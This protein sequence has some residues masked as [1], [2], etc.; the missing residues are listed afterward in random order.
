M[1]TSPA[2][3]SFITVSFNSVKTIERTIAS[4]FNQSFSDHEYL[5]IDGGSTDGIVEVIKRYQEHIDYFIS[6]I[7]DGIYDAMNKGASIAMGD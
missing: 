7:D 1:I 2:L 3:L 4:V 5:I 6:E